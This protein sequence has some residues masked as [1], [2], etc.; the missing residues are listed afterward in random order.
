MSLGYE[1]YEDER[2]FEQKG[3]TG[4]VRRYS[5]TKMIFPC[6]ILC[7]EENN[8]V[9]LHSIE[10]LRRMFSTSKIYDESIANSLIHIYFNQGNQTAKLGSIQP[11]QV[12][13]FLRLFDGCNIDC[14]LNKDEQLT[15]MYMY[16]LSN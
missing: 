15:G 12:K 2:D 4:N 16:V 3:L 5:T 9:P 6:F 1:V 8:P 7:S 14:Y 11:S 13:T 10:T